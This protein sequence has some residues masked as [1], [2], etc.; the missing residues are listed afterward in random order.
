[1]RGSADV[2][3]GGVWGVRVGV[4]VRVGGGG[5]ADGYVPRLRVRGSGYVPPFSGSGYVPFR[6]SGYVPFGGSGY[7][8]RLSERFGASSADWPDSSGHLVRVRVRVRVGVSVRVN[9]RVRVRVS[10]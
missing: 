2:E 5:G 9:V 6:G 1:M 8:P 10:Y 3:H 4:G 7:V